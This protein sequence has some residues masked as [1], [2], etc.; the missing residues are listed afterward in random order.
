MSAKQQKFGFWFARKKGCE[1]KNLNKKEWKE[2]KEQ[3]KKKRRKHPNWKKM[4]TKTAWLECTQPAMSNW[5]LRIHVLS[6]TLPSPT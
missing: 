2:K 3:K 6:Q 1:K 4:E 5:C